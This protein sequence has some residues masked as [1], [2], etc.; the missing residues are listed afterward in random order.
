MKRSLERQFVMGRSVG[1]C[2]TEYADV[3]QDDPELQSAQRRLHHRLQGLHVLFGEVPTRE[4]IPPQER[5]RSSLLRSFAELSKAFPDQD[6]RLPSSPTRLSQQSQPALQ[7]T[8]YHV[9][10][11]LSKLPPHSGWS[12]V[13]QVRFLDLQQAFAQHPADSHRLRS[14]QRDAVQDLKRYLRTTLDPVL[15]PY[16]G[17]DSH[18]HRAYWASRRV[19]DLP[20]PHRLRKGLAPQRSNA[21][22]EGQLPSPT[23]S[24]SAPWP[25]SAETMREGV[26]SVSSASSSIRLSG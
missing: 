9:A 10:A 11:I 23:L 5:V 2:L 21:E 19:L 16:S 17:C 14:L 20:S 22:E 4:R 25:F 12:H 13:V 26:I 8:A 7:E 24:T 15:G 6:F 3:F 18:F 1:L